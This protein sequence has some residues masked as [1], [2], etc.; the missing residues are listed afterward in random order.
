[1]GNREALTT[2]LGA[3][4]RSVQFAVTE[5]CG[6]GRMGVLFCSHYF[7]TTH[8]R[9]GMPNLSSRRTAWFSVGSLRPWRIGLS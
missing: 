2:A 9:G 6:Y 3:P 7:L 5:G 8:A 1:M 4:V